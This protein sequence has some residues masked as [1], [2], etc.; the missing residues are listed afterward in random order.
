MRMIEALLR[1]TAARISREFNPMRNV[2]KA[3]LVLP[4][5]DCLVSR[6]GRCPARG[7]CADCAWV[8]GT[9]RE[10]L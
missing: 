10:E 4:K 6:N 8:E 9:M 5:N 7:Q 2:A 1:R 3:R